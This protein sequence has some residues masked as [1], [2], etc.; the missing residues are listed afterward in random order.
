[1]P[2]FVALLRGVNVGGHNK[3]NMAELRALC[4]AL[5]L[6]SVET[7]VQSGNLVFTSEERDLGAITAKLQNAIH[8]KFGCRPDI[9][10]R[11]ARELREIIAANPFAKRPNLEPAKLL[12]SF[13][14]GK[15]AAEARNKLD[16]LAPG[17]EEV[18]AGEREL[19]IYFP[20]GMGKSK[21][22]WAA[23]N[24]VLGVPATGRNWNTVL[25]LSEM[26]GGSAR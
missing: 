18:H 15:P 14:A 26:A 5:K 11:T 23:L 12:V 2:T 1:M 16:R 24:K 13:L 10:L 21:F 20:N 8:K 17:P 6:T 4:G 9:I 25:K 3:V 19:Y 22:P 7:Y